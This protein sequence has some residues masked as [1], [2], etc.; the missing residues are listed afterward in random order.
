MSEI[1]TLEF[2]S[3][4]QDALTEVL[5]S[6]KELIYSVFYEALEDFHFL[7]AIKEGEAS[8]IATRDEVFAILEA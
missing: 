2:K 1:E 8:G 6:N 7:E 5:H 4:I 3:I